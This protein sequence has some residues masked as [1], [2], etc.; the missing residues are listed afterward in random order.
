MTNEQIVYVLDDDPEILK[1]LTRLLGAEGFQVR[2]FTSA[3]EFL[4]HERSPGPACLVLDLA[5]PEIDGLE[6]QERLRR[7][8][9]DLSIVFL[10]G[11]GSIPL[12]VRT[13]KAG[14]EDFLTKPV[15][16]AELLAAIRAA[17]RRAADRQAEREESL[18]LHQRLASLTP[19]ERE[20][21]DHVIAG[22]LNKQIAADL[23]TGE[24]N[25]KVHRGRL[26][27]KMGARSVVE[28]ARMTERLRRTLKERDGRARE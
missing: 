12:S 15:N 16:A 14:A 13:V 11:Y 17:L 3:H 20:V 28:L 6:V 4:A 22:Q 8:G 24:Q 26:M 18:A 25:I 27:R 19:R 23:G 21:L 9:A 5:M 7:G 10:S 2:G 1:A